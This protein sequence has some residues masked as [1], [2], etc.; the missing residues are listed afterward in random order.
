MTGP[1]ISA[2]PGVGAVDGRWDGCFSLL[3][4]AVIVQTAPPCRALSEALEEELGVL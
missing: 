1:C 2:D 4:I 3:G